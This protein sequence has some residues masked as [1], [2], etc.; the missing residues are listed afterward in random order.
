MELKKLFLAFDKDNNGQ[1]DI[2]E[3]EKGVME[4]KF[5]EIKK[6]DIKNYFDEIDYNLHLLKYYM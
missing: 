1:I 5:N 6:E 3:F 4:L 2:K